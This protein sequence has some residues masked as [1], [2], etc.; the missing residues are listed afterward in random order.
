MKTKRISRTAALAIIAGSVV[1]IPPA[2]AAS[3]QLTQLEK[4]LDALTQRVDRMDA[5]LRALENG[6]SAQ[7]N[8]AAGTTPNSQPAAPA[9]THSAVPAAET[10]AET[11]EQSHTSDSTAALDR[12]W[13]AL[14]RGMPQEEV[15]KLLGEPTRKLH[16]P[17]NMVLYYTYRGKGSGSITISSDGRVIDWQHP[18][19]IGGWF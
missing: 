17:P 9:A 4:K 5:R 15:Q 14:S 11:A 1:A 3:D 2:H 12:A 6:K 13:K 16:F 10:A 8:T 19:H 18:P 7:H